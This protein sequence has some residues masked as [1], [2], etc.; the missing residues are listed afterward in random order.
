M[1]IVV[2]AVNVY[3]FLFPN[4]SVRGA[5]EHWI[6]MNTGRKSANALRTF[7][8]E[9]IERNRERRTC[10]EEK[11]SHGAVVPSL[12]PPAEG[13]QG[14]QKGHQGC[15]STGHQQHQGGNLPVCRTR[16]TRRL[17]WNLPTKAQFTGQHC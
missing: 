10:S 3:V 12:C 6:N 14:H 2:V 7:V 17:A 13:N 8:E 11:N 5:L 16:E 15:H 1:E 4:V 9:V